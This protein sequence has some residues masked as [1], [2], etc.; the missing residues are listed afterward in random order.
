[1]KKLL[2]ACGLILGMASFA[3]K[4][5]KVDEKYTY[6]YKEL[7][8]ETDDY[9]VYVVD[10]VAQATYIKFKI[11]V[12]NKTNDYLVFRPQEIVLAGNGQNIAGTDK[13]FTI[14]PNDESSRVIDFKGTGMQ[15]EKF[16]LDLKGV[17]KVAANAPAVPAPNFDLPPSKNDFKA[18][19]FNCKLLDNKMKTDKTVAKFGCTYE[20]D[21]I[22]ILDPYKC[23][24]IMPNKQDNANSKKYT[25]VLLEKGKYEDFFVHFNEVSGAGDMQKNPISIKWNDTFK[26]SKLTPM[27]AAGIELLMDPVKTSERNK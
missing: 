21:G 26:E 10:A 4:D 13:Q 19:N 2:L 8:F 23:S 14:A 22:G 5:K 1:M 18:G 25:G 24:A 20:G 3:Q 15:Q 17:Y 16:T 7:S 11:K 12:F 6:V 9:K 27:K